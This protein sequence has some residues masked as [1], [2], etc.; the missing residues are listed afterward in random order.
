MYWVEPA[1]TGPPVTGY[2]LRYR[3]PGEGWTDGP[4]NV[5]NNRAMISGLS[6]NTAYEVQVRARNDEGESPWSAWTRTHTNPEP[7]A[8]R[9]R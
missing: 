5:P 8:D 3:E 1:N 7:P 2:D 9:W 4:Q 6:A